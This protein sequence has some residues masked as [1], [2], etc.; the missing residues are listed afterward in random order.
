M[1]IYLPKV[2]QRE[3]EYEDFFRNNRLERYVVHLYPLSKNNL[4]TYLIEKVKEEGYILTNGALDTLIFLCGEDYSLIYSEL[5]KIKL[6]SKEKLITEELVEKFVGY[7]FE[8]KLKTILEAI[9]YKDKE[10]FFKSLYGYLGS[11]KREDISY[12]I[13]S[14]A[15]HLLNIYLKRVSFYSTFKESELRDKLETL[16]KIDL[17]MKRGE[18]EPEILLLNWGERL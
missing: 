3:K 7:S 11:A 14:L 1:V 8:G 2:S 17:M 18:S 15:S 10:K 4:K 16:Y 5:N 13:G 12:L 9:S 6:Y